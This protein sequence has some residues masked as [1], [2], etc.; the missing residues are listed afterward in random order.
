MN[1]LATLAVLPLVLALIGCGTKPAPIIE[2]KAIDKPKVEDHELKPPAKPEASDPDAKKLLDEMLAAHTGGSPDKLAAFRECT[3]TRK[4]YQ[5]G[6]NGR[7]NATWTTHLSWPGRYRV[8][9]DLDLGGGVSQ[10]LLF[11]QS[12]TGAWRA[13]VG[14]KEKGPLDPDSR[15][16]L[17]TQFHEDA[18]ALLF[19]FTDPAVVA[20]RAE[21]KDATASEVHAW[22]PAV[23]Y[24]RVGLDAKTKLLA[25]L[26]YN[27]RE[28]N[29]PVMKELTF[30]EYKEFV[31]VKLGTKVGVR[32]KTKPL[33]EWTELTVDVT[34]PDPKVFDGP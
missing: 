12:P 24:V 18:L 27:G 1:R 23:G 29:V 11:G 33:G 7:F 28:G 34:K 19:P 22:V 31:G 8:R 9:M 6:A 5:E 16:T 15:Q 25:R 21:G 14:D 10:Q 13:A 30:S 17:T 3:F 20:T 2:A 4:G 26:T 32:T